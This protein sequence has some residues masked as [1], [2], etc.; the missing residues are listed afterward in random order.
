MFCLEKVDIRFFTPYPRFSS[1][2]FLIFYWYLLLKS[3]KFILVKNVGKIKYRIKNKLS[4]NRA[5]NVGLKNK[6]IFLKKFILLFE[7]FDV[8]VT[9]LKNVMKNN[10]S[11]SPVK[12]FIPYSI[13]KEQ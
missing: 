1:I 9:P 3:L 7:N 8:S 6:L 10:F 13:F 5:Y 2:C 4:S 12:I 11:Q